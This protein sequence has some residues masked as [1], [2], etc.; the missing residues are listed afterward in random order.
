M[1]KRL[2]TE[3]KSHMIEKYNFEIS[4]PD[5]YKD[6]SKL[7]DDESD[8]LN[9]MQNIVSGEVISDYMQSL[10]FVETVKNLKS[11][12][13]GIRL[14]VEAINIEKTELSI[15]EI[16]KRYVVMFRIYNEDAIIQDTK[17]EIITL[18]GKEVGKVTL[19]VKGKQEPSVI[20]AYLIS[21]ED[22]EITVTFMTSETNAQLFE[23]EI[24]DIINSLKIY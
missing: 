18:D 24:N 16:C 9:N 22:R 19:K 1:N 6:I 12:V 2:K 7:G 14:I 10:N 15:E 5:S 20:I 11:D 4:Y 17:S 3:L 21:L 13:N 23:N 8:V